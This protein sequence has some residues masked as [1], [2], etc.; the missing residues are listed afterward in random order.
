MTDESET[1]RL[2]NQ[3]GSMIINADNEHEQLKND[4]K[5]DSSQFSVL[6]CRNRPVIFDLGE[7]L[8]EQQKQFQKAADDARIE[9]EQLKKKLKN[10][11]S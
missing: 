2:A 4:L 9:V 5:I 11:I 8:T 6:S 1:H 3:I 7:Q 10:S